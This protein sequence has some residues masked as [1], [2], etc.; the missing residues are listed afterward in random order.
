ML[1]LSCRQRWTQLFRPLNPEFSAFGPYFSTLSL[2]A[3]PRVTHDL[4]ALQG[5]EFDLNNNDI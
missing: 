4:I 5:D 2:Q 1:D 3:S